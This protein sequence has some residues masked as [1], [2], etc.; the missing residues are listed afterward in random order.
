M[1]INSISINNFRCFKNYNISFVPKVTVLIG[2]NGS[3]K[4]TILSAIKRA[5]S[6]VFSKDNTNKMSSSNSLNVLKYDPLDVRYD[7]EARDYIYP[8]SIDAKASFLDKPLSWQMQKRTSRGKISG[9][10]FKSA[11]DSFV[12]IRDSNDCW[13]IFAYFS[14]S[15][16][17]RKSH[18]MKEVSRI[19]NSGNQVPRNFGYYQWFSYLSCASMW[20]ERFIHSWEIMQDSRLS[21]DLQRKKIEPFANEL[22]IYYPNLLNDVYECGN[23]LNDNKEKF[24]DNKKYSDILQSFNIIQKHYKHSFNEYD[25]IRE[26]ILTF[27]SST[28]YIADDFEIIDVD[29]E[30]RSKRKNYV[31]FS[32]K[33]GR[34]IIADELP[35]G[36]NRL[37][38]MVFDLA[39]RSF[40]LTGGDKN[41]EVGVVLID[42]IDIHLHPS[43]Q[44]DVIARFTR[45]FPN[46]QFIVTTHSPLVIS[47]FKQDENNKV[48]QLNYSD[49]D[50]SSED[51]VSTYGLDYNISVSSVMNTP[52]RN[53]NVNYLIEAYLRLKRKG[54]DGQA[55]DCLNKLQKELGD[56]FQRVKEEIDK[57]LES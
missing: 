39:Y 30:R 40:I 34:Q 12:N 18:L 9:S 6:F 10:L 56:A 36:Y 55:E 2:K 23:V 20:Q 37:L 15:Y 33:D 47:N 31:R 25:Y 51:I 13:P 49:G 44:Q 5:L 4:S 43:L 3:G 27:S 11:F 54:K 50:Y 22:G 8:V 38:S 46:I 29:V 24:I 53:S 26:C 48:I 7:I 21:L 57:R 35:T 14:D 42:E 1:K 17:H 28:G 19:L 16:P 32:F 45:T 41:K 52:S